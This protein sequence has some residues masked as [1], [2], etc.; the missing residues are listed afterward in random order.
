VQGNRLI[1]GAQFVKPIRPHRTHAEAEVNLG[2][3]WDG[4]CHG[5][6]IVSFLVAQSFR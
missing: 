6:T 4:D 1:Y 5:V 2:E 3:G